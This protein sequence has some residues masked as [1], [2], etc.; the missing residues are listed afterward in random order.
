MDVQV[1]AN[2]SDADG[3]V[4]TVTAVTDPLNGTTFNNGIDVTYTPDANFA[5]TDTFNYTI[6]DGFGGSGTARVTINVTAANDP[7]LVTN[8]GALDGT[9]TDVVSVRIVATDVDGDSVTYGIV[10]PDFL[11]P[12]L[13]SNAS[14]GLITGTVSYDAVAHPAIQE[15]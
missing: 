5:G 3:D 2:D 13:T 15:I 12:N 4:L 7:P 9:E 1:L 10:A 14:T 6:V 11:P 8:P